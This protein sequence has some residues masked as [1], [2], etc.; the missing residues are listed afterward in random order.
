MVARRIHPA[1]GARLRRYNPWDRDAG[2]RESDVPHVTL[3][4][5]GEQLRDWHRAQVEESLR[6]F[7]ETV[8]PPA[9]P[10]LE[11]LAD[12]AGAAIAA[13][14]GAYPA[15]RKSLDSPSG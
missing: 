2:P 14:G 8:E 9:A 13:L 4:R 12:Y 10:T 11:E 6:I 1:P 7:A 5:L 3:G 15:L